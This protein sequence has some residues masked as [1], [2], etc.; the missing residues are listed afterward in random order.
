MKNK[1]KRVGTVPKSN[2]KIVVKDKIDTSNTHIHHH[3]LSWLGV[4]FQ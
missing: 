1:N 2:Q 4:D 3:T